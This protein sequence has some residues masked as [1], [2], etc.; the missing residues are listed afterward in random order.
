MIVYENGLYVMI[1][2]WMMF[3][4]YKGGNMGKIIVLFG[5]CLYDYLVGVKKNEWCKILSVK[6]ILVK[7]LFVKKDGLKGFGYYVEYCMDDVCLIIE[8][9]KKVVEFGVNV[10]NYIKVEYFLYD[11]NK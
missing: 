6:E 7:N 1:F 8:V 5:I 4:F 10:I 3:L 11:D 2:E 9:M